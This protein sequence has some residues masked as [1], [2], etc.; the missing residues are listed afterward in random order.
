MI[1]LK[2]LNKQKLCQKEPKSTKKKKK[3]VFTLLLRSINL[4]TSRDVNCE[5]LI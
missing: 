5:I 2:R 1:T 3:G 4:K